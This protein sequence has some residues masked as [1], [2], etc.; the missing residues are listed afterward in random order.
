MFQKSEKEKHIKSD[1]LY[2]YQ[3]IIR[4]FPKL[5][6]L[7]II[8]QNNFK[9]FS[10]VVPLDWARTKA[11]HFRHIS[12]L[13]GFAWGLLLSSPIQIWYRRKVQDL[14]N[15]N[16][17][18]NLKKIGTSLVLRANYIVLSLCKHCKHVSLSIS[19]DLLR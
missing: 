10:D 3:C 13:Y 6:K 9:S 1:F 12:H 15:S 16:A 7:P 17:L 11:P 8:T 2:L 5:I 19:H 4:S 18:L 14:S